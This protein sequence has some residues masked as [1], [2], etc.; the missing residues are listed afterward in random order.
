M[1]MMNIQKPLILVMVDECP[2]P[3]GTDYPKEQA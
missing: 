3:F 2:K 1:G